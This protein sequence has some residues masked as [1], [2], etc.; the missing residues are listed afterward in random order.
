VGRSERPDISECSSNWAE[1]SEATPEPWPVR[2]YSG[3]RVS[4]TSPVSSLMREAATGEDRWAGD[5]HFFPTTFLCRWGPNSSTSWQI[6]R[7]GHGEVFCERPGA[8]T[9]LPWLLMQDGTNQKNSVEPACHFVSQSGTESLAVPSSVLAIAKGSS[10]ACA[11][12]ATLGENCN[13]SLETIVTG[14]SAA[15]RAGGLNSRF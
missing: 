8:Q 1:F 11:T 9:I 15:M 14:V 7:N 5:C 13:G 2:I 10:F 6:E 3:L 12:A 4:S